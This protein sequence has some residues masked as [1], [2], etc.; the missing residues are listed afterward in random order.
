MLRPPFF[1]LCVLG[2]GTVSFFSPAAD[3]SDVDTAPAYPE[4]VA[5]VVYSRGDQTPAPD[6]VDGLTSASRMPGDR[7]VGTTRFLAEEAA[8][9]LHADLHAIEPE[10]ALP[11]DFEETIE[12]NR[13]G[14]PVRLKP[15]P[16][17]A[18]YRTIVV[19]GPNWSMRSSLPMRQ[20]LR[21]VAP[22]LHPAVLGT[23]VTHAQYGP[24]RMSQEVAA[25][26]PGAELRFT[27][28]LEDRAVQ[29]NP[30]EALETVGKTL[31]SAALEGALPSSRDV[32]IL[33]E[34]AGR[35][36]ALTLNGSP[37]ADQFL[38]MLPMTVRMGEFGGREFYGPAAGPREIR[39]SGEGDYRFE[40]GTLTYCP[41]NDTVAI[42]YD[43]SSRPRLTMSVFPMGRVTSDLKVFDELP[44]SAVFTFRRAP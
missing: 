10:P 32:R 33:C 44:S 24:G 8:R 16:D 31:G 11:V 18:R 28:S 43:Q 36:I 22:S 30:G 9:L 25:A 13:R 1:S 21:D 6:T 34:A 19:A 15:L 37:E 27:I 26:F 12:R 42:F 40:N 20:F 14:D 7:Q 5:V 23:I 35:E 17:L 38:S 29:Q 41:T 3:A 4:P 2:L 39:T